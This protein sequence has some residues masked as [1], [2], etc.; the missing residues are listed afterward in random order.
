MRKC[1]KRN[2]KT[3]C[4]NGKCESQNDQALPH[5]RFCFAFLFSHLV[6]AFSF[7][8]WFSAFPHFSFS[9]P[10]LSCLS[11]SDSTDVTGDGREKKN[12]QHGVALYRSCWRS[13]PNTDWKPNYNGTA[14]CRTPTAGRVPSA[15][16]RFR[17][18]PPAHGG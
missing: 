7:R 15:L 5:F 12:R 6:F 13:G 1:E 11:F 16:L 9:F 2:A 14:H 4:K 10:S 17:E 3:K 18:G 8:V